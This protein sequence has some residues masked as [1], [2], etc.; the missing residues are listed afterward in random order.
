MSGKTTIGKL[1][2]EKLSWEFIDTDLLIEKAYFT[3][4]G[5][6][7][8]CR[9][10][11]LEEGEFFFRELEKEQVASLKEVKKSIISIGGGTL[12]DLANTSQLQMIGD[13][14]YLKAEV[15]LLWKRIECFGIPAYLDL[16]D[17]KKAFYEMAEKRMPLYEEASFSVIETTHLSQLEVVDAI[18]ESRKIGYG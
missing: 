11:F 14:F 8:S 4:V 1:L 15:E 9:Q 16:R 10:I 6:E 13:L 17:P 5:E 3:K 2:K 12:N 7:K 18:L